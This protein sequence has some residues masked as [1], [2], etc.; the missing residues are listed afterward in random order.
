[1]HRTRTFELGPDSVLE[2]GFASVLT[3]VIFS[4][5]IKGSSNKS[6]EMFSS[7]V[8]EVLPTMKRITQKLKD[9]RRLRK[10]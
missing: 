7:L 9:Q 1:M 6:K 5:F 8:I 3:L 10:S 4:Y 2:F